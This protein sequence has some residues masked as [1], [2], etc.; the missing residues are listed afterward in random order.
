MDIVTQGIAGAACAQ[1][2]APSRHSRLAALIG[3]GAGL[4]PD[5]DTLIQRASDPLLQLEF[6]RHFSHALVFIPVGAALSALLLWPFLY[7]LLSFKQIYRYALCGYASGGLLDAC[8]SYGTHLLWPFSSEP[9]AWSLIAIVD[10][11]FTLGLAVPLA[12]GLYQRQAARLGLLLA[13]SYLLFGLV[14]QQRAEVAALELAH[15]RGH[16]PRHLL[17]KPTVG[18]LV[19]WRALYAADDSLWVDAVRVGDEVQVYPGEHQSLFVPSRDWPWA[20]ADSRAGRDAQRFIDLAKGLAVLYPDDNRR[21]GDGRYALLPTA[22][23]PL[24]G[25]EFDPER[26]QAPP[27]WIETRSLSPAMRRQFFVLLLG[28]DGAR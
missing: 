2:L 7:R 3:L 8:T 14:Q 20:G 18:N 27:R 25:L 11:V 23:A 19:L 17:V 21:L 4:L 22:I 10:P 28:G 5:A 9:V 12:V 6:H 1:A 24:W 26:P 13:V 15:Q 16:Q